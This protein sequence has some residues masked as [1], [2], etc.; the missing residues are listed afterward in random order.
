MCPHIDKAFTKRSNASRH[1]LEVHMLHKYCCSHC[2]TL[3]SRLDNR[4]RCIYE[5]K[6]KLELFNTVT[7]EKGEQA[8]NKVPKETIDL[9]LEKTIIQKYRETYPTNQRNE[10]QIPIYQINKPSI[11]SIVTL[12]RTN[13]DQQRELQND[14]K[15]LI[16]DLG[17]TLSSDEEDLME[18]PADFPE[19]T[20]LEVDNTLKNVENK[21]KVQNDTQTKDNHKETE[22]E[23]NI[24]EIPTDYQAKTKLR[25]KQNENNEERLNEDSLNNKKETLNQE[26]QS[27]KKERSNQENKTEIERTESDKENTQETKIKERQRANNEE[28]VSTDLDKDNLC[29]KKKE[30]KNKD[31]TGHKGNKENK[32]HKEKHRDSKKEK[33]N[34]KE[35]ENRDGM[36]DINTGDQKVCKE[37]VKINDKPKNDKCKDQQKGKEENRN[38]GK[39]EVKEK[40]DT[41][42]IIVKENIAEIKNYRIPKLQK[43]VTKQ[44]NN[45]CL[46]EEILYPNLSD[47]NQINISSMRKVVTYDD[48]DMDETENEFTDSIDHEFDPEPED[49]PTEEHVQQT[50]NYIEE[51][52]KTFIKLNIG[53]VTFN[54]SYK[55]LSNSPESV[56]AHLRNKNLTVTDNTI[57]IDRSGKHFEYLLNFLRNGCVIPQSLLP[58]N[59]TITEEI[60]MESRFYNICELTRKLETHLRHLKLGTI[61]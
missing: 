60:L 59:I 39:E 15:I 58:S 6:A 40:T 52:Q 1:V 45:T 56:L 61:N 11:K 2:N 5:H 27:E 20:L 8:E 46:R 37:T 48:I 33:G 14:P 47:I 21:S 26:K 57:F 50:I 24:K 22:E 55:T 4:H 41:R 49:I 31:K 53:G 28:I 54:T 23:N 10:F 32:K 12:P 34:K 35:R 9:C 16:N 51:T 19:I 36:K 25:E 30:K 13:P 7:K 29:E 17:L 43:P 3:F 18:I 42:Q 38:T 44:T